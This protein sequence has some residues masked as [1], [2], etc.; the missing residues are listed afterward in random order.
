MSY[1]HNALPLSHA[2]VSGAPVTDEVLRAIQAG[3]NLDIDF[4]IGSG[5]LGLPHLR[6]L[7]SMPT[8]SPA[9]LRRVA[10]AECTEARKAVDFCVSGEFAS[11]LLQACGDATDF[12]FYNQGFFKVEE[13]PLHD[14]DK[15]ADAFRSKSSVHAVLTE[16]ILFGGK[17]LPPHVAKWYDDNGESIR[18]QGSHLRECYALYK[19]KTFA[20]LTE[21][22]LEVSMYRFMVRYSEYLKY[23]PVYMRM[24]TMSKKRRSLGGMVSVLVDNKVPPE[25]IAEATKLA[26]DALETQNKKA[27]KLEPPVKKLVYLVDVVSDSP[28]EVKNAIMEFLR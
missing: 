22:I 5:E 17:V 18:D 4:F 25:V 28:D 24:Y 10:Q 9:I 13:N 6:A 2:V 12:S 3:E 8:T 15:G 20:S 26:L 16:R 11:I 7:A 1:R 14:E 27:R 23:L 21:G 19:K